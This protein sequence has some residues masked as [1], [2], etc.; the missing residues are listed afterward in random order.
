MWWHGRRPTPS[1]ALPTSM[2]ATPSAS[3]SGRCRPW[4]AKATAS[5]SNGRRD[6]RAVSY[7]P[8]IAFSR[9]RA[10]ACRRKR[11]AG[12]TNPA[13]R[14]RRE[15]RPPRLQLLEQ[16]W[17]EPEPHR[18]L[19]PVVPPVHSPAAEERIGIR[20]ELL[21]RLRRLAGRL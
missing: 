2:P 18:R 21:V 1:R 10:A 7:L 11:P 13:L 17:P 15:K 20:L 6:F 9:P 8:T 19:Q 5:S 14:H 12:A 4:N 16:P 3:P